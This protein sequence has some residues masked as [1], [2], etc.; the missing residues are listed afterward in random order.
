MWV[1]VVVSRIESMRMVVSAVTGAGAGAGVASGTGAASLS[2]SLFVHALAES[3]ALSANP[4]IK[5]RFMF[6]STPRL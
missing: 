5:R 1:V 3:A 2:S 6:S 4:A